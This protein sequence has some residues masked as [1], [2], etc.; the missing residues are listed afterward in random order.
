MVQCV[1][2]K[3]SIFY[4]YIGEQKK[5]MFHFVLIACYLG[6]FLGGLLLF[7]MVLGF[8]LDTVFLFF[9]RVRCTV[10]S[11]SIYPIFPQESEKDIQLYNLKINYQY[12]YKG[13]LQK[14]S[15]LNHYNSF[16]RSSPTEV[17]NAFKYYLVN[18]KEIYAYICPFI[19]NYAVL[20]PLKFHLVKNGA[21]FIL[22]LLAFL[23]F[24]YFI[25]FW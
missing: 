24:G 2:I 25:S 19:N 10:E 12:R 5:L 14:S 16:E 20:F 15:R 11:Y 18:N 17:E 22:C 8:I 3:R 6:I 13:S 7:L 4:R 9:P 21:I 23:T 1:N